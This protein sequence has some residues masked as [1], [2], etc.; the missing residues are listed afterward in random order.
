MTLDFK[1]GVKD[2]GLY[3]D[4]KYSFS[5]KDVALNGIIND[6]SE[7][8]WHSLTHKKPHNNKEW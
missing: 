5:V 3:S 6:S 1:L 7:T 2:V 8:Q 4:T